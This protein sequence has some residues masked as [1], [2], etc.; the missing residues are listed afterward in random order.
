MIKFLKRLFV[1][2]QK[3]ND[4]VVSNLT[5]GLTYGK[6]TPENFDVHLKAYTHEAYVYG[7]I[8]LIASTI[9][10]LNWKL[11]KRDK[12]GKKVEVRNLLIEKLF[13]KPNDNDEN[14][15]WYNLIEW[16]VACLELVGNSYWLLDKLYGSSQK[17]VG[18]IQNLI[19]SKI[20]ILPN[21]EKEGSFI[22]GYLYQKSDGLKA[23]FSNDEIT[24]FKYIRPND[25][26]YG[27]GAVVPSAIAIDLIRESEMTN[28]NLF[29]NGAMPSGALET[30]KTVDDVRYARIK[31]A[32]EEKYVGSKNANKTLIL[33]NGLKY[34]TISQSMKDLEFIQGIKLSREEICIAFKVPPIL[35]GILDNASY[36]NYE[37]A[38]KVF[39]VH[40]II[41]KIKRIE[42]VIS[43]VCRRF[44]ETLYFE[45]D[46]STVESL[47]E[48]QEQL[49]VIAQRYFSMGIPLNQIIEA[50]KL[51]F[52]PIEGGDEGYIQFSLMPI[53]Q[54]SEKEQPETEIVPPAEEEET[55]PKSKSWLIRKEIL[56]KQFDSMTRRIEKGYM[57]FIDKYFTAL[58]QDTISELVKS[59]SIDKKKVDSYLFDKDEEI[60]KWMKQS[61]KYQKLAFNENG[62]REMENIGLGSI[63]FNVSNPRAEKWLQANALS[64]AKEVIPTLYDDLKKQLTEGFAEGESIPDIVKRLQEVYAGYKNESF[65]AERIARTEVI[66]ASNAGA[67]EAYKQSGLRLLKG[68]LG[69]M[70]DRI[71]DSHLKATM[72]YTEENAIPMD[73]EFV[74]MD[75][76]GMAPGQ[77]DDE[78]SNI[79]CRCTIFAV[80][81]TGE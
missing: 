6:A 53:S 37:Q 8:Y 43:T 71:R 24:H 20:T 34:K 18:A 57:K 68:W 13:E 28:L 50:L 36:S 73:E 72:D 21:K 78:G 40:C 38:V 79:N 64:K 3:F 29:K 65:K 31:K 16:T 70:D 60:E 81:D 48:N 33:D 9:A 67:L 27:Q 22:K 56:W 54:M 74:L 61:K 30:D 25:Y 1:K 15:T 17:Y 11:Y 4:I 63:S 59:K 7:C 52:E 32:F 35:I 41:P 77:L 69:E 46:L 45:F 14:S 23:E 76:K 2:E 26:F 80:R 62:K 39:W 75:G 44:D 12:T 10:G 58:E 5:D 66:G 55:E 47:K 51:P 49:S 42:Q 19:P